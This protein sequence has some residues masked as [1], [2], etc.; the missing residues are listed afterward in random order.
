MGKGFGKR[1]R[2]RPKVGPGRV[3]MG[4]GFGKRKIHGEFDVLMTRIYISIVV[5]KNFLWCDLCKFSVQKCSFK[6]CKKGEYPSTYIINQ[7]NKE[8]MGI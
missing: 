2:S 5:V 8:I 1:S 6:D 3:I 7:E 4:K